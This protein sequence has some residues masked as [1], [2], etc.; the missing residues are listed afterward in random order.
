MNPGADTVVSDMVQ[1]VCSDMARVCRAGGD[2]GGGF[3]VPDVWSLRK[4]SR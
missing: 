3:V 2:E 1:V 4:Q